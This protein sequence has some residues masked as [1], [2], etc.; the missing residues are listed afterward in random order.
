MAK[1]DDIPKE[2]PVPEKPKNI[3][4]DDVAVL[5]PTEHIVTIKVSPE[6]V[7]KIIAHKDRAGKVRT[8]FSFYL[9]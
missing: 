7:K 1:K 9:E 8:S 2:A 4:L 6:A 3:K 5:D